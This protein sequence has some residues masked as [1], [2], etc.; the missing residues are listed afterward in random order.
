MEGV[1][2]FISASAAAVT[3]MFITSWACIH[4]E[5][6][7]FFLLQLNLLYVIEEFQD[8][9]DLLLSRPVTLW[10]YF[11]ILSGKLVS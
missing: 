1:S 6:H 9:A 11:F 5:F 3:Q 2:I 10:K 8:T 7:F 4:Q